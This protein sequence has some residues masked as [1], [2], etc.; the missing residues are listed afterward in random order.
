MEQ[1]LLFLPWTMGDLSKNHTDS[2]KYKVSCK[3]NVIYRHIF[4]IISCEV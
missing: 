2:Y 3:Y 4:E 1:C